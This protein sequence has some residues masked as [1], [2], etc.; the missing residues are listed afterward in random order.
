[1]KGD[2]IAG[3]E[4]IE[5]GTLSPW[6]RAALTEELHIEHGLQFV[7]ENE[8]GLAGWCCCRVITPE[9]ELCKIAVSK[10]VRKQ[11][12][13]SALVA[14][15]IESLRDKAVSALFLEVR[16]GNSAAVALYK[17]WG[18]VQVGMRPSYYDKPTDDALILRK[19]GKAVGEP[20][21][22]LSVKRMK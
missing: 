22:L 16:A 5:S 19:F 15:L 7:A 12:V 4:E 20:H 21:L 1:M 3:V 14:H 2:D 18:F 17:K 11:G 8:A 10:E 9:A 6:S 13:A